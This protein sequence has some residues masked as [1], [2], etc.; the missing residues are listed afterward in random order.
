MVKLN[1]YTAIVGPSVMA[2]IRQKAKKLAGK[3][4][5]AISS[6][7]QGGGVAEILNS[8]VFLM[9]ELGINFGW[10]II[11]GTPDFFEITKI[12]H[13]G[14]QGAEVKLTNRQ[15]QVYL[16]VLRRF[17]VF[18][19]LHHDLV[20]IHDPQP[21]A[22][23]D[24]YQKKQP[25]IWRCHVD[26]SDPGKSPWDFLAAYVKKYD[27][28]V[29]SDERYKKNLA[30]GQKIIHPA[31]DPLSD[32][33]K[34]LTALEIKR[35]LKNLGVNPAKP[36]IAQVSRFDLFKDPAGAA[37]IFRLVRK[38]INCQLVLL[39]NTASDD[40]EG[41]VVYEGLLKK[42]GRDKDIKIL[43][44][45][46]ENDLAVNAVQRAASVVMQKSTKEGF[47]LVA[48]EALYKG[49]PVVASGVGG[50][51]LQV[52]NNQ[53]GFVHPPDDFLG[54]ARSIEEI[55]KNKKLRE[56]LGEQGRQHVIDHFLITRLLED[57]L[58][59]FAEYLP[60]KKRR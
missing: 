2:R 7:H 18:N 60:A 46:H 50:L 56:K 28:M 49:T 38:K 22:L 36:I 11:H 52:L 6:T 51:P 27:A 24:F 17:S 12:I 41:V 19:H 4:I 45:V 13:N 43:I 10:R 34:K 32:K 8:F 21:L 57:W 3:K 33:N 23:I 20:I 47:G 35:V 58:D 54:F 40:P 14:L 44:N 30:V 42:Y 39:G 26:L 9:N 25:W 37:E 59:L 48:A 29:V 53:T 1:D 5:V 31:I 55:L 16:E 15:K